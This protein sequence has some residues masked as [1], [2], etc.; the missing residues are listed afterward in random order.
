MSKNEEGINAAASEHFPLWKSSKSFSKPPALVFLLKF[1]ANPQP[2]CMCFYFI[3]SLYKGRAFYDDLLSIPPSHVKGPSRGCTP[4]PG[5]REALVVP[6]TSRGP[7]ALWI[8]RKQ[9]P[10]PCWTPDP[11]QC[12]ACGQSG[13]LLGR[14]HGLHQS[15]SCCRGCAEDK[16]LGPPQGGWEVHASFRAVTCGVSHGT[17]S[18]AG[19]GVRAPRSSPNS[20]PSC[21][22][23]MASESCCF[24]ARG[25][26]DCGPAK[27]YLFPLFIFFPA[28]C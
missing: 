23:S 19:E 7:T 28:S 9:S 13:R 14:A 22:C 5:A 8:S 20:G 25:E 24:P 4:A 27:Y 6:R 26:G 12:C 17:R 1:P 10:L 21:C 16:P 2:C 15:N 11:A 18:H 3:Q